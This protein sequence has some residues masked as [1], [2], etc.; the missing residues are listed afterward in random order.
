MVFLC[1]LDIFFST[2]W[3]CSFSYTVL[4]IFLFPWHTLQYTVILFLLFYCANGIPVFPWHSLQYI[5]ILFLLFLLQFA[6]ACACLA[7]NTDQKDKLA[8][9]GWRLASS[10]LRNDVQRQY[11]C[12][13]FQ[14]QNILPNDTLGHPSCNEVSSFC[15]PVCT[16]FSDSISCV[17]A[18]LCGAG[19]KYLSGFLHHSPCRSCASSIVFMGSGVQISLWRFPPHFSQ[20][21]CLIFGFCGSGVQVSQWIFAPLSLQGLCTIVSFSGGWS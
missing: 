6:L 8:E 5:V 21:L 14:D 17:C 15:Y 16:R 12:C 20:R 9:H 4:M 18:V 1:F 19:F 11:D 3:F 7:V 13:G 10:E 2:Q